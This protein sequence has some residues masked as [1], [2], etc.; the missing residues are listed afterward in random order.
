MVMKKTLE[1]P[2]EGVVPPW[3]R[4]VLYEKTVSRR[5]RWL[6]IATG[7]FVKLPQKK[8]KPLHTK[9][10]KLLNNTQEPL[11][12]DRPIHTIV[13]HRPRKR[14]SR[15]CSA[16]F[17]VN[18]RSLTDVIQTAQKQLQ[19]W[20]QKPTSYWSVFDENGNKLAT[21]KLASVLPKFR[22]PATTHA[23][24]TPPGCSRRS[25]P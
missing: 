11:Q 16:W 14:Q 1:N 18:A 8:G 20:S 2:Q 12:T 19:S 3:K 22:L 5:K 21:G 13:L 23:V 7:I 9:R 24:T 15:L 6:R 4:I 25:C 17:M 10:L